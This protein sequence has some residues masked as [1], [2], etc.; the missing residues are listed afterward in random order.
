MASKDLLLLL[1]DIPSPAV[2]LPTTAARAL[3]AASSPPS[4]RTKVAP[5]PVSGVTED[6]DEAMLTRH[7]NASATVAA[8]EP[9]GISCK[10][11]IYFTYG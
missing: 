4:W 8:A 11:N 3:V 10:K 7:S 5:E 6:E 1:L 2:P 9:T